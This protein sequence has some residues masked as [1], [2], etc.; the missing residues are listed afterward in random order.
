MALKF[1][2]N[3]SDTEFQTIP[4][5]PDGAN[6]DNFRRIGH[7]SVRDP[8]G[9]ASGDY[10]FTCYTSSIGGTRRTIQI[11]ESATTGVQ[12]YRARNSAGWTAWTARS[13]GGV[14]ATNLDASA[15]NT[16]VTIT[17][18]TGND[19]TITAATDT[20][21]GVMS[22]AMK[23]KLDGIEDGAQVNPIGSEI[24]SS[25]DS[26][27]GSSAWQGAGS[28]NLSST[29]NANSVTVIS[30]TGG[31]ATLSAASTDAA[32]VMSASDKSNLEALY[33]LIGNIPES[34]S[35][36]FNVLDYGALPD[37]GSAA[38]A[39]NRDAFENAILAAEAV[40]GGQIYAPRGTY[41]IS[42]G[43][44]ASRGGVR[45]R[46]NMHLVGDGMGITT[47]KAADI[48]N[49][50]MAGLVRTQSGTENSNVVV[51]DLTIDAN[52]SEQT[53]WSNIIC[54]FAG[55]TPDNRVLMDRDIWC[56]N[57]ECKNGKNG[58][59]GSSNLSRG[60]GFDP[61]EVVDR[62][63]A[64]NCI[65]H[66]CERDGF[67][68]DGVLNF[69]LIGCKSWNSGRH[70]FNF[71]TTTFNGEVVGCHA[72]NPGLLGTGNN[73][74]VQSNSSHIT[75][76]GCRSRD[77]LENGFRIRCGDVVTETF[78]KL[79]GCHIENSR[80]NGLQLTGA[81]YNT[82]EGCTFLN[83]GYDTLNTYF[84]VALDEDDGDFGPLRGASYN[85]IKNNLAIRT[86]GVGVAGAKS[87]YRES[88]SA[89]VAPNNNYFAWNEAYGNYSQSKY[90]NILPGTTIRDRGYLDMYNVKDHGAKGDGSTNDG[91]ALRA[92]IDTIEVAGGGTMFFPPGTY[93]VGG[94][95]TASQ[96]GLALPNGVHILGSGRGA[97][98]IK[99]IDPSSVA[100]T[101]VVRSKSA[102]TTFGMRVEHITISGPDTSSQDVPVIYLASSD[103]N[104]VIRDVNVTGGKNGVGNG[105]Y[106]IRIE[107]GCKHVLLDNVASYSNARDGIYI[108][109]ATDVIVDNCAVYSNTRHGILMDGG[110][111]ANKIRGCQVYSNGTNNL[112]IQ[113]EARNNAIVG[114]DF[115][116][117][118]EDNLRIRRGTTL[119]ELDNLIQSVRIA[120]SGRD[121]ISIA[122]AQR[123]KIVGCT[124]VNNG[125]AINN[126][127]NDVSFELD[128]TFNT[129]TCQ[130]NLVADCSMYVDA[131]QTNKTKY[132]ISEAAAAA[133]NN[134]FSSNYGGGHVTSF[135][136]II[137]AGTKK[138][139]YDST[140]V[141]P[142]GSTGEIQYN[143]AG[144]FAASPRARIDAV[145]DTPV[146]DRGLV[147]G[148][149][150][151]P[152]L[153]VS[154]MYIGG[155][156]VGS[157]KQGY[158]VYADALR[159]QRKLQMSLFDKNV[160]LWNV[161][162]HGGTTVDAHG[163]QLVA[164]T[165]AN[166]TTTGPSARSVADA[167]TRIGTLRRVGFTGSAS[168]GN[169]ALYIANSS[170]YLT[171]G[172]AAGV[173][174]FYFSMTFALTTASAN[175][176]GFFGL[177]ALSGA[178]TIP[179]L[180]SGAT[181]TGVDIIGLGWDAGDTEPFLYYNDNTGTA[182]K[183]ALS[184]ATGGAI[185]S[186][187]A[188]R[189][190]IFCGAN[191]SDMS[192]EIRGINGGGFG[193]GL[194]FTT[195]LPRANIFLAPI[196]A[197]YNN[198]DAVAMGFDLANIYMEQW[199]SDFS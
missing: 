168:A 51:R 26:Q 30:D 164:G 184:G 69:Q 196:C 92:L 108:N 37:G 198:T 134:R 101:G 142:G 153:A 78:V 102:T 76:T 88:N 106:G 145:R 117:S 190:S 167:T 125:T 127:Y 5:I 159:N 113:G 11:I 146:F 179:W 105:G 14:A 24:V 152:T 139:D 46:S 62:F 10:F 163:I 103:E 183:Q 9:L 1:D 96:G 7:F 176:R 140:T 124:F 17:S 87:A 177:S 178:A 160:S 133:D 25:I 180:S 64:L 67:V 185:G 36:V 150:T 149:F 34:P 89:S 116:L 16:A 154:E 86:L 194:D 123:N 75:F 82:V 197:M 110:A 155:G 138:I 157:A 49:N 59:A 85:T 109:G 172:N 135:Y 119:F 23:S 48:G 128:A 54:F 66:D 18:D 81:A 193:I 70:N 2:N 39:T 90:Y 38:A 57:V 143:N 84:D 52:K 182:T 55:V 112:L 189:L 20:Q 173:G 114:G 188:Y 73:F 15:T 141:T 22:A 118:G 42:Y 156:R 97:T 93:M 50:D 35:R 72:W 166:W 186:N 174:G 111:N 195:N 31:D 28:T 43:G 3:L 98:T 77:S 122:G 129:T 181:D 169:G 47:I 61:H 100:M 158:V 137:G 144:A 63:V 83:N 187:S 162:N 8:V 74:T 29:A 19:A 79:V 99:A 161:R 175:S 148:D 170:S 6:L 21:A 104:V 126:T 71:I 32:G 53:G 136:N 33:A 68:L 12:Q 27:L 4:S 191:A 95:G 94:T 192:V 65:A 41:Y 165:G 199:W 91:P 151:V 13:G 40:G 56:I 120:Q 115:T 80:K 131:S 58:T 44:A 45:L 107:S 132:A 130:N 121:G 60:Y 171:R 147:L